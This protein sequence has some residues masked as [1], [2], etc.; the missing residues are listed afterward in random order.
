[1][2]EVLKNLFLKLCR[3]IQDTWF[4]AWLVCTLMSQ[5]YY[6][7]YYLYICLGKGYRASGQLL[8]KEVLL[9]GKGNCR[10]FS[11]V[12]SEIN[13]ATPPT[14]GTQRWNSYHFGWQETLLLVVMYKGI[15]LLSAQLSHGAPLYPPGFKV[16]MWAGS[17]VVDLQDSRSFGTCHWVVVILIC[18]HA[19]KLLTKNLQRPY[20]TPRTVFGP[21]TT[22]YVVHVTVP[23]GQVLFLYVHY[24][25]A[26]E[27][28]RC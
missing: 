12:V 22:V 3:F 16:S 25:K 27:T 8:Q 21:F 17:E 15:W 1:M 14:T 6:G 7:I 26:A 11:P 24:F 4:S 2:E 10:L 19:V 13:S 9:T 28:L 23:W 20:C 5:G 18:L